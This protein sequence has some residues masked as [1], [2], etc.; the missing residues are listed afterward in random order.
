MGC[1]IHS[2]AEKQDSG[3]WVSLDVEA[4]DDRNYGLFGWLAGVRNYSGLTPIAADRGFPG[5]ASRNATKSYNAWSGD[6]H[7]ASWVSVAE[8]AAVDY[9]QTIEDRRCTKQLGP[10]MWTGGATC[11]P[12][13]GKKETLRE[14]LGQG[15]FT[16]LKRL[17]DAGA[18][19]VVFWFD[20]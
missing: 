14:F 7:S 1:D 10:N 6:A 4:F 19:R 15:Y 9:D 11:E 13:E 8:L 5:D 12:G 2:H 3:R 16:V 18:E 17:Q 20:N